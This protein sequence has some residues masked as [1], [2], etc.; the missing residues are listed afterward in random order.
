[1]STSHAKRRQGTL[2][3]FA[4]LFRYDP[5]RPPRPV[6]NVAPGM[7]IPAHLAP[8]EV[9]QRP[10]WDGEAGQVTEPGQAA[11]VHMCPDEGGVMPCCGLT[12]FEVP[13]TDRVTL[14]PRLVTC[15]TRQRPPQD[16]EPETSQAAEPAPAEA[17]EAGI[18]ERVAA[19]LRAMDDGEPP[20]FLYFPSVLRRPRVPAGTAQDW[21]SRVRY[22][23]F[24]G[25]PERYSAVMRHISA[26]TG[27]SS[28]F[29]RPAAWTRHEI[30]APGRVA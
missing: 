30:E 2:A 6:I 5:A 23:A 28:L 16:D 10:P 8:D 1:M 27:T 21:L 14:L 4:A 17:P 7:E 13:A 18:L 19:G 26:M 20:A 22:P 12:P 24:D 11:P 15:N 3:R 9:Q 29:E 25:T